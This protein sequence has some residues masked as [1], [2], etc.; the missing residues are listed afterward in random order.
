[1]S[2]FYRCRPLL[3]GPA[4]FLALAGPLIAQPTGEKPDRFAY[5]G[6]VFFQGFHLERDLPLSRQTSAVC[7]TG[8]TAAAVVVPAES[9]SSVATVPTR[10]QEE[11]DFF[12]MRF[13]LNLAFR[14]SQYAEILYGLEVGYLT[15]GRENKDAAGNTIPYG[16]GS[17]GRGAE[18]T[19][20]ETRELMLRLHDPADVLSLYLGVF[21]FGTP[22]GIVAATSG[23]GLKFTADL[24]RFSSSMEAIYIRAI[25]N[26]RV[27]DDSN[28]YSDRNFAG[29]NA[30]TLS[31]K[32]SGIRALRSELYGAF[33]YD[34]DPS[35]SDP[36]ERNRETSRV[37]WGGLFLQW[38]SGR[39]RVI[40][41]GIGNGGSFER[42]YAHDVPEAYWLGLA[43]ELQSIDNQRIALEATGVAR[44]LR[45]R[46]R[47]D[48]RAGQVEL[49]FR[50]SDRVEIVGEAGGASGRV[51]EDVEPDGAQAG[52]RSDQFRTIGAFQL[53]DIGIDSSGG[54]S[55]IV[56][57]RLTG[58]SFR[59]AALRAQLT[60]AI[61]AE[62]SVYVYDLV[63]TPTIARNRF[64]REREDIERSTNYFG[65]EVNLKGIWR[66]FSDFQLEGRLALFDAGAGYKILRD[67]E[68]GDRIFEAS[69]SLSQKF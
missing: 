13:R 41:H 60:S 38:Q 20:L 68:Y 66:P 47:I 30:G 18:R 10:C 44:P 59:S 28:G 5:K 56:L 33:Y 14:P 7:R 52:L 2:F 53:S 11:E 31:W 24:P 64:Y 32:F 26:S 1:M 34:N 27:D 67:V 8:R 61:E 22:K 49:G 21:S 43:P 57:G 51:P 29:V 9:D 23:G 55:T 6:D 37:V 39:W 12:R 54:Y 63:H 40:A 4:V 15:F 58:I 16:P 36:T 35:L 69:V 17:G 65:Q 19:N 3:G 48:A 45:R 46:Y 62:L 50:V 42:P 25:D